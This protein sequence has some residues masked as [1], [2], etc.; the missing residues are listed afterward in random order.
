MAKVWQAT[1]HLCGMRLSPTARCIHLW[2]DEHGRCFRVSPYHQFE[3]EPAVVGIL[4][5][6]VDPKKG[7]QRPDIVLTPPGPSG[8]GE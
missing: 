1:C 6:V 5:E 3:P 8:E 2:M 7:Y 4:V